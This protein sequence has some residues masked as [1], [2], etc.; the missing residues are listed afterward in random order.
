M[1]R[2]LQRANRKYLQS[3]SDKKYAAYLLKKHCKDSGFSLT[4]EG[5]GGFLIQ[6]N[7]TT[8]TVPRRS[9]LHYYEKGLT[10]RLE[11]LKHEYIGGI[12]ISFHENDIIIDCGSNIGEFICSLP[13]N[14]SHRIFAFEPDPTEYK[15]L[16][17]NIGEYATVLNKALWDKD[18]EIEIFL[19]NESGDTGIYRLNNN[20]KSLQVPTCR[21]DDF[22]ADA[23][24]EGIIRL[25]KVEAEGAEPE[26]LTGAT[27]V[28]ERTHF[29]AVDAGPERGETK[30]STLVPVLDILSKEGFKMIAFN[31]H[32]ITCLFVNTKF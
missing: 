1:Y 17:S 15:A 26:V 7:E 24:P 21:L 13:L 18:D 6:E 28:L 31:P 4:F 8:L 16:A 12:S 29:I 10:H 19:A 27:G 22:I 2:I 30:S 32:R 20:Q 5:N 11:F 23:A 14:R 3:L 25:L 9:R